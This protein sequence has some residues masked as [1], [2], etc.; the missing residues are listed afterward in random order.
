M[1]RILREPLLQYRVEPVQTLLYGAG[2][3]AC[4]RAVSRVPE[5]KDHRDRSGKRQS[6]FGGHTIRLL[7]PHC[8]DPLSPAS[9]RILPSRPG[10]LT[11]GQVP[12]T[13]RGVT[14]DTSAEIPL[15]RR[16]RAEAF[17]RHPIVRRP[18]LRSRFVRFSGAKSA[19]DVLD[20]GAGA[21]FSTFALARRT[22]SVTAVDW[23]P[24]LLDLARREADRRGLANVTFLEADP[25]ALP[26]AEATFDLVTSAAA[27]HHFKDPPRALSEMARVCSHGGSVAIEDVVASE[28]NVRARYHNRI[29]RLRDRSHQRLLSL[30]EMISHLGQSGLLARR[31]EVQDSVREYNE[32]VGVTRP[33]FRRSEHIRRLLQGS[34]E[35]D[36]GGLAV[37]PE[38]DT[39]LFIQQIAWILAVKPA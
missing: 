36:L 18:A 27:V 34:V 32:W 23:R 9:R 10:S 1:V 24:D 37:Q 5:D 8:P 35:R 28:Q 22:A 30:S 14:E 33:P 21:G 17:A 12:Y 16:R 20:I 19:H 25:N 15:W 38:D 3:L 7:R 11:P 39:F 26:F 13:P 6:D 2:G 29:E 31:V 4:R